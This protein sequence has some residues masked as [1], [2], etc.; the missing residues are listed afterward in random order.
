MCLSYPFATEAVK[1]ICKKGFKNMKEG[2]TKWMAEQPELDIIKQYV[3][4]KKRNHRFDEMNQME[5]FLKLKDGTL[6]KGTSL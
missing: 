4:D 6:K 2:I 5:D 3:R 1:K